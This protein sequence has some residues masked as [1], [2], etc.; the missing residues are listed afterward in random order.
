MFPNF[1]TGIKSYLSVEKS[2]E[3]PNKTHSTSC[4]YGDAAG[5]TLTSHRLNRVEANAK[6]GV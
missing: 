2:K 4:D 6:S 3:I 5:A 1:Q